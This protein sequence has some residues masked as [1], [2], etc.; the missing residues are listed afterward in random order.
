MAADRSPRAQAR[1][2]AAVCAAW[3][4]P[5]YRS[6]RRWRGRRRRQRRRTKARGPTPVSSCSGTRPRS[7]PTLDP[8]VAA[9]GVIFTDLDTAIREHP[10]LV[11]QYFMTKA[12][13]ADIR[14]VRGAARRV[15]AG[16][17]VPLCAEG[18]D[19]RAAVPLVHLISEPGAA[20][21]H[22]HAGRARG[23]RRGV[24]RRRL[25]LAVAGR[26]VVRLGVVELIVG[27]DAKLRYVQVQDWGRDVWN[28]MTERAIARQATPR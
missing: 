16:R 10:E 20:D 1:S 15:L 24:C 25:S 18:R 11:K 8:D 5:S 14:Q 17:L 28:F 7:R 21:L 26:A 2:P 12:V 6:V 23:G 27:K 4:R 22:P 3:R 13:P 9:Q 19:G